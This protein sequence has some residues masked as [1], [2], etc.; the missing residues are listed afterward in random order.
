MIEI[1]DFT[2]VELRTA[3][4]VEAAAVEGADR[5][6]KLQLDVDGEARQIV[7]GIAKFYKADELINKNIVIVYNLKPVCLRG[8][9]SNGMLLAAK[10]GK[11]K[12]TLITTD[13]PE[14]PSG[15]SVG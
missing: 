7:A 1:G 2:K 13:D 4:I 11:K 9:D 10:K 14:F 5:L 12:L 6:L 15:A 8:V 3:R